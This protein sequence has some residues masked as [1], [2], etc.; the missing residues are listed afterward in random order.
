MKTVESYNQCNL[1]IKDFRREHGK[2]ATNFYFLPN[3]LKDII[4]R[5]EMKY[6]QNKE[7]LLFYV[8]ETDFS[9]IFYFVK[10]DH[11]PDVEKTEKTMILDLVAT[12]IENSDAIK[13][14][15]KRWM[16]AG[17]KIYKKYVRLKYM[18][19]KES[20]CN[21]DLMQKKDFGLSCA[22]HK[23]IDAILDLWRFNLDPYSIPLPNKQDLQRMIGTGH[24]Y[25][26]KQCN[27]LVGAAYMNTASKSCVLNHLVINP[28]YRRQ[29]LGTILM[30]FAL[31]RMAQEGIEKCY[32]WVDINNIPVYESCKKYGFQEEGLW[33]EQML[34]IH[35]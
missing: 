20:Y 25:V 22:G 23:D 24:V 17:F 2:V 12:D 6:W 7:A 30:D 4:E 11:V 3:E 15:E 1:L 5:R 33:S 34:Y 10:G 35:K 16:T 13:S 32:P 8:E 18:I 19:E 28:L 21:Q 31:R 29:G 27:G 9:H 14:E 26:M